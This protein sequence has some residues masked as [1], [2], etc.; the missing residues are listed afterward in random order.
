MN[1]RSWLKQETG[2]ELSA[3]DGELIFSFQ[4]DGVAG[5]LHTLRGDGVVEEVASSPR[6]LWK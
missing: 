5:C 6:F 1:H 2:K 3:M 4:G